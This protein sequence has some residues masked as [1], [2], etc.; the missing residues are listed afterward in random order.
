MNSFLNLLGFTEDISFNVLIIVPIIVFVSLVLLLKLS[1]RK[2]DTKKSQNIKNQT[3]VATPKQ[4]QNKPN[5]EKG[6]KKKETSVPSAVADNSANINAVVTK[7]DKQK[8]VV[9][10]KSPKKNVQNNKKQQVNANNVKNSKNIVT[11]NQKNTKQPAETVVS[12]EEDGEWQ[13]VTTK[14]QKQN[15]NKE[16]PVNVM[17]VPTKTIKKDA[18]KPAKKKINK[19]KETSEKIVNNTKVNATTFDNNFS[20]IENTK[21]IFNDVITKVENGDSN[22]KEILEQ[23]GAKE[24]N[25]PEV[26]TIYNDDSKSYT[27]NINKHSE[28]E[29]TISNQNLQSNNVAFDELGGKYIFFFKTFL[30]F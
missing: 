3:K 14:K 19:E 25:A 27:N 8:L 5:N 2:Q 11:K 21:T 16:V 29:K 7:P 13:M 24:I 1:V 26:P 4:K 18:E 6:S 20:E 10:E 15:K 23:V 30:R 17:V 12:K 22:L 9:N 28:E